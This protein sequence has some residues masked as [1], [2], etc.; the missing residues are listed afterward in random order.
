MAPLITRR[1]SRPIRPR[2][3]PSEYITGRTAGPAGSETAA[4]RSLLAALAA[5]LVA[6]SEG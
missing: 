1:S 3:P 6:L 2:G 4:E 5:L